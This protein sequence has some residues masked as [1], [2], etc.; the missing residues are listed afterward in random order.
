M[1]I[2]HLLLCFSVT[3]SVCYALSPLKVSCLSFSSAF[4]FA[5][6]HCEP[7]SFA[8]FLFYLVLASVVGLLIVIQSDSLCVKC[9]WNVM[10]CRQQILP[11]RKLRP[12]AKGQIPRVKMNSMTLA[13]M[14]A[15]GKVNSLEGLS[16][17]STF[18]ELCALSLWLGLD[19][20]VCVQGAW[21]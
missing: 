1:R 20:M 14:P 4:A 17:K 21:K 12:P 10:H 19:L 7:R 16:R 3:L 2:V 18:V 9:G 13:P 11:T 8:I 15:L 6:I 5:F